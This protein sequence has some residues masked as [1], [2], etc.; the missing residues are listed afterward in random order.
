MRLMSS[1][2]FSP[3][4]SGTVRHSGVSGLRVHLDLLSVVSFK[5][6]V[7]TKVKRAKNIFHRITKHLIMLLSF[8]DVQMWCSIIAKYPE[9]WKA[10]VHRFL[11][12][13]LK[14]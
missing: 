11:E 3:A 10:F 5:M 14:I 6:Q 8:F 9:N 2:F 12:N 7:G 1:E 4:L 13:C